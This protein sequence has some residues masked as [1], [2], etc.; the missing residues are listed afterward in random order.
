MWRT[1]KPSACHSLRFPILRLA[2]SRA[3]YG[4]CNFFPSNVFLIWSPK[5]AH[6]CLN[7]GLVMVLRGPKAVNTPH[8]TPGDVLRAGK[9]SLSHSHSIS[10]L[11]GSCSDTTWQM[12]CFHI[13][14]NKGIAPNSWSRFKPLP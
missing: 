9:P 5:E 13:E 4:L 10:C 11:W 1:V 6:W 3:A 12:F 14:I 2:D 7:I 8:L